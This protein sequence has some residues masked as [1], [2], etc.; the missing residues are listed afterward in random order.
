MKSFFSCFLYWV[1]VIISSF[2]LRISIMS[3]LF[4]FTWGEADS[5]LAVPASRAC[6]PII[7][8]SAPVLG[9]PGLALKSPS[10]M[11]GPFDLCFVICAFSCR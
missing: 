5:G 8:L 10:Q 4:S 6:F 9:F 11:K 1:F 7:S 2:S 3:L